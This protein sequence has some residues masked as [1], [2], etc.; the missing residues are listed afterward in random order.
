MKDI[1][2][3]SQI[4]PNVRGKVSSLIDELQENASRYSKVQP[5]EF[6][7][8]YYPKLKLLKVRIDQRSIDPRN[9]KSILVNWQG[10]QLY[11]NR[12]LSDTDARARRGGTR[13]FGVGFEDVG[14]IMGLN[15]PLQLTFKK[16]SSENGGMSTE[17][18]VSLSD[19]IDEAVLSDSEDD[20]VGGIDFN[21]NNLD[22]QQQ[23]QNVDFQFNNTILHNIQPNSIQ[24]ILPVI[25]N[26]TPIT[27][28]APL[29]GLADDQESQQLSQLAE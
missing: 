27:N 16:D 6:E 17:L 28:F 22:L 12:F 21:P 18:I 19:H 4:D 20:G 26:I 2:H 14:W 1:E 13:R 15:V 11:G 3:Y 24:G 29:L 10:F 23:G 7:G 9:W 8:K 25:I 5:I